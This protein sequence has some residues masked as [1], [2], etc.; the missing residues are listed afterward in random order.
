[1]THFSDDQ[2]METCRGFNCMRMDL[3]SSMVKASDIPRYPGGPK[4]KKKRG[5]FCVPCAV[6]RGF[7]VKEL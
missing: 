5:W 4:D 6:F 2:H 1:M 3:R 7:V